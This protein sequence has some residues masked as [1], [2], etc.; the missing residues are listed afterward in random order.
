M[1]NQELSAEWDHPRIA[2]IIEKLAH[3]FA[4]MYPGSHQDEEDLVQIG[5]ITAWS[6]A[7]TWRPW[8]G[9]PFR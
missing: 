1:Q 6:A 8:R 7:Q 5:R 2:E 9:K 3:M 4:S